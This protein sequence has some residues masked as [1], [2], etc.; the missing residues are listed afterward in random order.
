MAEFIIEEY[1]EK[2]QKKTYLDVFFDFLKDKFESDKIDDEYFT[3]VNEADLLESLDYFILARK[4]TARSTASAYIGKLRTLFKDLEKDYGITNDIF[5]NGNFMPM[6]D[7][8]VKNRI[9][10][11]NETIDKNLATDEQY[12]AVVD[13]IIDFD[14]EYSYEKVV[15][16]IDQYLVENSV[17]ASLRPFRK[18]CSICATQL[19]IEY[20]LKNNVIRDIKLTDI[21]LTNNIIKR[22]TIKCQEKN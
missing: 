17:N 7:E 5:I 1:Y 8:K 10:V 14:N 19:V 6:F 22:L 3:L 20:G 21:D 11:L 9:S 2:H 4:V 12:N 18:L 15:E 13:A 16:G